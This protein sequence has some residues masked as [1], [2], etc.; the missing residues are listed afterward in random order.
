VKLYARYGTMKSAKTAILISIKTAYERQGKPVLCMKPEIDTRAGVNTIKSRLLDKPEWADFV[1]K[2]TTGYQEMASMVLAEKAQCVLVDEGQ[3]LL[4][5]NVVDLRRLATLAPVIVFCL[6]TDYLGNFFEGSRR[7]FELADNIEEVKS[8]CQFCMKKA[9]MN[10]RHN[11]TGPSILI[12]DSEY[13]PA[14][15]PCWLTHMRKYDMDY[16]G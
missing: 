1:I 6:R 9:T 8:C 2:P 4:K 14:C 11:P 5:H 12:G 3:F 7:L 13:S 15:F 16:L 10:L